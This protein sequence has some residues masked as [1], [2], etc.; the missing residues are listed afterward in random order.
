MS[1]IMIIMNT[2]DGKK[3]QKRR[4]GLTGSISSVTMLKIMT[5]KSD[6]DSKKF[7]EKKE[8]MNI[9]FISGSMGVIR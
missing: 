7:A 1:K 9:F 6:N 3:L 2:N 5:L 8:K 4:K